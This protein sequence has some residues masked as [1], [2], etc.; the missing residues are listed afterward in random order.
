MEL[1]EKY[2][3]TFPPPLYS[4]SLF[5]LSTCITW[6]GI[7]FFIFFAAFLSVF[8]CGSQQPSNCEMFIS[9][10]GHLFVTGRLWLQDHDRNLWWTSATVGCKKRCFSDL[11]SGMVQYHRVGRGLNKDSSCCVAEAARKVKKMD[12]QLCALLATGNMAKK[13]TCTPNCL[14][15]LLNI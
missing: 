10:F 13:T 5:G 12:C 11:W 3:D 6:P 9:N 4:V 2:V 15:L 1:E 14:L 7:L 8:S